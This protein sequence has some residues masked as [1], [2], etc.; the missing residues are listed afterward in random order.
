M[1]GGSDGDRDSHDER[2]R[3]GGDRDGRDAR[4]GN[5][6]PRAGGRDER[7]ERER[8]ERLE[9][10]EARRRR[11]RE[12]AATTRRE[13]GRSSEE[14]DG[15]ATDDSSDGPGAVSMVLRLAA[16]ALLPVG[17]VGLT[18]TEAWLAPETSPYALVFGA[19][20]GC[21]IVSIYLA[22]YRHDG[23]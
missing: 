1:V 15:N 9:R 14:G 4:A 7:E 21:A 20:V 8:R 10:A 13:P 3:D 2:N 6:A 5:R 12:R 23:A 16:L 22:I 18:V 11:R 17:F 19:G